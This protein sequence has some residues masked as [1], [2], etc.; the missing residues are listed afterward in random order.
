M[1]RISSV[2]PVVG[3]LSNVALVNVEQF[4]TV[5]D[6]SKYDQV[7]C[8]AMFGNMASETIDFRVVTCT[9]AGASP[10]LLKAAT[11][12]AASATVNDSTIIAMSV[13]AAEVGAVPA[14]YIKFG[15]V[16]GST[17]GGTASM[18]V[19]AYD[20]RYGVASANDLAAVLQIKN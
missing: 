7:I 13:T 15:A 14:Q 1:F 20:A 9:S 17:A 16:T 5:I 18:I 10:V 8:Y 4:S 6:M 11:Q 19:L 12:L 2:L 3:Q